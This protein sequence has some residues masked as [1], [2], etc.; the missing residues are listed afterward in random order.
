MPLAISAFVTPAVSAAVIVSTS[1]QSP[2]VSV[3]CS[4]RTSDDPRR[5]VGVHGSTCFWP[6]SAIAAH[7]LPTFG[8][9]SQ[10]RM[11]GFAPLFAATYPRSS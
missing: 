8:A 4:S 3:R 1:D 6:L 7:Q 11:I 9:R 10:S 5:F 2:T